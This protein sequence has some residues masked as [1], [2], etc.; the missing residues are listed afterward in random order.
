MK[1]PRPIEL[2]CEPGPPPARRLSLSR[3]AAW[4]IFP[5]LFWAAILYLAVK[6]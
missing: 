6:R 2:C 4:I 1:N 5:A 3:L